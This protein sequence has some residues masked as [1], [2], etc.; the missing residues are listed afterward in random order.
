MCINVVFF[1]LFNFCV[2]VKIV[3]V[4]VSYMKFVDFCCGLLCCDFYFFCCFCVL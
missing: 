2:C 1:V 3:C 4:C